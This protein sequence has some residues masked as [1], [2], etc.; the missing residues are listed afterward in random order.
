MLIGRPF[1]ADKSRMELTV[2]FQY[3]FEEFQEA[4]H[5]IRHPQA[6]RRK[7]AEGIFAWVLFLGLAVMLY[8]LLRDSSPSPGQPSRPAAAEPLIGM[9]PVVG[10]AAIGL[11]YVWLGV[12]GKRREPDAGLRR[13]WNSQPA[14]HRP[15]TLRISED[16]TSVSDAVCSS[17]NAWAG[18]VHF[19][20]TP[21]LFLLYSTQSTAEFIPKRI[22]PTPADLEAFRST[23]QS[24]IRPRESAFPVLP[25][26]QSPQ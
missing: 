12:I 11:C 10:P 15:K 2:T 26:R 25:A 18:Y 23:A 8:F 20:E 3:T 7:V 21:N 5:A 9:L 14:F 22:F 19:Q 6:N 17:S 13:T 1:L 4:A 16:G 24:R